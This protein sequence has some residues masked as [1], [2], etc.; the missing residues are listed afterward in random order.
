MNMPTLL[1]IIS[2][3]VILLFGCA[4]ERTDNQPEEP[5]LS[6]IVE[7][8]EKEVGGAEADLPEQCKLMPIGVK[9]A[10]GPWG[11]LVYSDKVSSTDKLEGLVKQY[12]ELDRKRNEETGGFSTGDFATEPELTI[13]NGRCYGEGLYAWNPGEIKEKAGLD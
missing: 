8:I 10:G 6:D 5:T 9:P 7:Q 1:F 3:G 11:Y 2:A 13:R 4:S 12:N